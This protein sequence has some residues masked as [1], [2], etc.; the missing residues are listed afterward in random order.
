MC[1]SKKLLQDQRFHRTSNIFRFVQEQQKPISKVL[2]DGLYD[3]D[4]LFFLLRGCQH[5]M[6]KILEELIKYWETRALLGRTLE[7]RAR[8]I[9]I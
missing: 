5:I 2:L 9:E 7:E 4:C 8:L 6:R 1:F 3:E